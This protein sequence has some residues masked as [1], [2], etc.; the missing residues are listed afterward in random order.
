MSVKDMVTTV[1][2]QIQ[3]ISG[4]ISY[5]QDG[6]V[7]VVEENGYEHDFPVE[8]VVAYI[9]HESFRTIDINPEVDTAAPLAVALGKMPETMHLGCLPAA[10][11]W[12]AAISE[13]EALDFLINAAPPDQKKL[14][15]LLKSAPLAERNALWDKSFRTV[16]KAVADEC[17]SRD[18]QTARL[19]TDPARL[20]TTVRK[21]VEKEPKLEKGDKPIHPAKEKPAPTEPKA[22]MVTLLMTLR[23]LR[24]CG[25]GAP[26]RPRGAKRFDI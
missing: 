9:T 10:R 19:P 22:E 13:S 4:I 17:A 8:T 20:G 12:G 15:E 3:K 14:V 18:L 21:F 24:D 7:T 6:I 25:G 23:Q 16:L 1:D 26:R 2:K 5:H 11:A